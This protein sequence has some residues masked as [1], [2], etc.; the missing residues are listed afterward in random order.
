MK[1][2]ELHQEKNAI[3]KKIEELSQERN[4]LSKQIEVEENSEDKKEKIII[5]ES[6]NSFINMIISI[7]SFVGI[8]A[9]VIYVIYFKKK[10]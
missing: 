1:I 6:N 2:E 8:I 3:D 9:G 5:K 10:D 7:M 4:E